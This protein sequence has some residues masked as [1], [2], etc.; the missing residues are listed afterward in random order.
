MTERNRSSGVQNEKAIL[1]GV[2]LDGTRHTD[3]ALG[4]LTGLAETAGAVV[5]AGLVQRRASPD[6]TTYLGKGKVQELSVMIQDFPMVWNQVI[7]I[8]QSQ[9]V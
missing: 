3:D 5:E 4:E 2:L 9:Q 6:Q 8:M 7:C 1:V